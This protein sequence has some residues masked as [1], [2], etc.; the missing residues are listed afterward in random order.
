MRAMRAKARN[1]RRAARE[2]DGDADE[3]EEINTF[4]TETGERVEYKRVHEPEPNA[5]EPMTNAVN[6]DEDVTNWQTNIAQM[7]EDI[8]FDRDNYA[9]GMHENQEGQDDMMDFGNR[10]V[11]ASAGDTGVAWPSQIEAPQPNNQEGEEEIVGAHGI[12]N[13]DGENQIIGEEDP[14]EE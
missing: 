9:K 6:D 7:D 13:S 1:E 12:N 11:M 14:D 8:E 10:A 4:V 2:E 3:E 5:D